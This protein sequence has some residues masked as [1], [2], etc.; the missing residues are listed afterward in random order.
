MP[1]A[2]PTP[3]LKAL[4]RSFLNCI[5]NNRAHCIASSVVFAKRSRGGLGAPDI[6]KYYYASHLRVI[7]S[8]FSL[9]AHNHWTA[10]ERGVLYP[11]HPCSLIWSPTPSLDPIYRRQ[12]PAPMN[13]TL[14]IWRKCLKTF[15]LIS[16]CSP[17][18]NV[19]FNP[20]IPDSLSL[21]RV[22]PW[23]EA[24]FFQLWNL[25]HPTSHR[26]HSFDTLREKFGIPTRLF[27]FYLQTRHFFHSQSSLLTLDKPTPFEYLCAQGP[28][29]LH[30]I[31]SIHHILMSQHLSLRTPI[32]I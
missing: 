9:H 5:W 22:F 31:S 1:V 4:Q 14:S 20:S 27:L 29:Q 17:L 11:V 30:L 6:V 2:I 15:P 25:V 18:V 16:P 10:I 23:M 19:L 13:V 12:S 3:Q 24:S 21:G 32:D 7:A 28:Q 8:W 26:L